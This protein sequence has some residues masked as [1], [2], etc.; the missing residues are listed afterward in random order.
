MKTSLKNYIKVFKSDPRRERL[1]SES[2][3]G[4]LLS[5]L[6]KDLREGADLRQTELAERLGRPQSFISK[7]ELGGYE[8]CNI[9]TLTT[10]ARAMGYELDFERMFKR[11]AKST[12]SHDV[13]C[14][15][16]TT[17]EKMQAEA[18][19]NIVASGVRGF[20]FTKA[21]NLAMLNSQADESIAA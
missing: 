20:S 1:V 16:E 5:D 12:Y 15:F 7:L 8:R 11:L 6:M 13:D 21:Q 3:A 18:H 19:R 10:I 17:F 2:R 9:G 4:R 14:D